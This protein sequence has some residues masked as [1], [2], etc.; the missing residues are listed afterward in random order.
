MMNFMNCLADYEK[1][2]EYATAH[3]AL[4]DNPDMV[5]VGKFVERINE[6]VVTGEIR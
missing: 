5:K 6:R 3:T 1:R 2:L 4:P